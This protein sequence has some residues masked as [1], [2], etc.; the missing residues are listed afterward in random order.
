MEVRIKHF[1]IL[2][3]NTFSNSDNRTNYFCRENKREKTS[4]RNNFL[5]WWKKKFLFRNVIAPLRFSSRAEKAGLDKVSGN[6]CKTPL[7]LSI[8]LRAN[9]ARFTP[10]Y[11]DARTHVDGMTNKNNL[12]NSLRPVSDYAL[13]IE[14]LKFA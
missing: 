1:N 4:V 9:C 7:V 10:A 12:W 13:K 11:M 6:W 2:K 5:K 14:R 3:L 8:S